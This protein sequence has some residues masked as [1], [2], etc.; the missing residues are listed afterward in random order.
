MAS[1]EELRMSSGR[2]PITVLAAAK[3][4]HSSRE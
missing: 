1:V 4:T 2:K 3:I